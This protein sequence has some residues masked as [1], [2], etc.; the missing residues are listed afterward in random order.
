MGGWA[1]FAAENAALSENRSRLIA[2]AGSEDAYF[3]GYSVLSTACLSC[4][5]VGFWRHRDGGV[6]LQ[7]GAP[8]RAAGAAL[9]ALGAV[10]WSQLLPAIRADLGMIPVS[11]G[12]EGSSPKRRCP[13]DFDAHRHQGDVYGVTR[14]TRHPQLGGIVA[15]GLGTACRSSTLTR[16]CFFGFGPALACTSLAAHVDRKKRLLEPEPQARREEQTSF[17]PFLAFLDGRQ[18]WSQLAAEASGPNAIIAALAVAL[19][20]LRF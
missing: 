19:L 18:S 8:R 10:T 3:A 6:R 5:A 2:A 12:A 9:C 11:D 17:V 13:I 1:A 14:V 15:I 16:A 20:A 4:V 7:P